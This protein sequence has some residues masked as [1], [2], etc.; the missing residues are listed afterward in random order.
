MKKPRTT[1]RPS[2]NA[3]RSWS[4]PLLLMVFA[5]G[6]IVDSVRVG[7]GWAA[8]GPRSGLL[9][10]LHRPAAAGRQRLDPD[11]HAA[12][13]GSKPS[14]AFAQRSQLASVISVLVP[15]IIYVV[16]I[17]VSRHLRRLV[18]PDRLL[19]APP[20]QVRLARDR[21]RSRSACR[22]SSSSSSN[23]GSSC[24]SPRVRSSSCSASERDASCHAGR[25]MEEINNLAHGFAVALTLPNLLLH[26]GRHHA[27][28][29]DRRAAR[30]SAA[31]TAS[32]SCC[33]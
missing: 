2:P 21:W 24:P 19:H 29:A 4:S 13:A 8:D 31:R 10:V 14:A 18:L 32:R 27:R 23:A 25:S 15:M 22:S 11:P 33:R 16:A 12:A 17:C 9:P 28:R 6:V 7:I 20:R 5:V 26:A 30:A 1:V 3:A